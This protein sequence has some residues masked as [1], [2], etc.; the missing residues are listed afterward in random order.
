MRQKLYYTVEVRDREG[1]LLKHIRR[2]ARSFVQAYNQI[3]YAQMAQASTTIKR[4]AGT[5]TTVG[6]HANSLAVNAAAADYLFGIVVGRGSTAVT[7]S[8][9]WLQTICLEGSGTNEVNYQAVSLTAPSVV[10]SSCSF[11]VTRSAINTS[12][13][14]ITIAEIG[15][16][17][18]GTSTPYYFLLVRDVLVSTIDVPDGG[19]ITV[20]YT[21]KVTV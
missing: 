2:K 9:Y 10:G 20:V 1:K 19:A 6:P 8:D 14:T 16:I 21:I 13:A 17:G 11:T 15:L 18:K 12:G 5:D 3:L 4:T 7:I